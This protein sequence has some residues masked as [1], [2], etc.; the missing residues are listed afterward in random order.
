MFLGLARFCQKRSSPW[1]ARIVGANNRLVSLR[2]KFLSTQDS[3]IADRA[4][5]EIRDRAAAW[6]DI[7]DH[8]E[9]I[10]SESLACSPKLIVELGTRGGEST[11]CLQAAAEKNAAALI[12]V[13]LDNCSTVSK[14][15]N[16]HFIQQDD[17][18]FASMFE[19]WCTQRGLVPSID[20]L[21]VDTSHEY[22]HTVKEIESWFPWLSPTCRVMFHDTNM[23]CIYRRRD[24]SFGPGWD[25]ERGV[26]R[27]IEEFMGIPISE[28]RP[29]DISHNGW[30]VRHDP[31]CN[32]FTILERDPLHAG[33]RATAVVEQAVL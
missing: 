29:L 27:A 26:I 16:W 2:K 33:Y 32:G 20:V 30:R 17:I 24:G 25:N 23:A 6:S 31:V 12:S 14:Y 3:L 5:E 13:D 21:L 8:L 11:R 10:Y 9:T 1:S 15:Q 7:S 28:S 22:G 18:V 4:L 19:D